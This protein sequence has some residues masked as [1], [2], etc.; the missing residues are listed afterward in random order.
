MD[1]NVRIYQLPTRAVTLT[2]SIAVDDAT[3]GTA[4]ITVSDL[5][6]AII[7]MIPAAEGGYF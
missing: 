6:E 1:E 5:I 4:Q 7:D 2:D 3:N